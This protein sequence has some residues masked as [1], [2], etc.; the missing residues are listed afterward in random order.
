M[1]GLPAVRPAIQGTQLLSPELGMWY[2]IGAEHE[3]EV[4]QQI[5]RA[6]QPTAVDIETAG[7]GVSARDIKCVPSPA[8]ITP[9]FS[10]LVIRS[11]PSTCAAPSSSSK[12]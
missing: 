1:S 4:L 12:S 2:A 5:V 7:L 3:Y 8:P 6:G 9:S 10:I 11:K